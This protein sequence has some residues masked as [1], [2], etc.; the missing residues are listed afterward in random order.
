MYSEIASLT[1]LKI[2]MI[3]YKQL[4]AEFEWYGTDDHKMHK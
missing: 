2:N 3:N 4:H 1:Q